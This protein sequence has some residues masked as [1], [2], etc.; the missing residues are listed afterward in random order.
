MRDELLL[1][2]HCISLT[3][4]LSRHR[5]RN[6]ISQKVLRRLVRRKNLSLHLLAED[7]KRSFEGDMENV[8]ALAAEV[9]PSDERN[10]PNRDILGLQKLLF[11]CPNLKSFSLGITGGYGGCVVYRHIYDR[12]DAFQ[13]SGDET[14]PP[15]EELSL[16]GYRLREDEW[17]HWQELLQWS[18]LRSLTLGP[19]WQADFLELAEGYATSLQNLTVEVYTDA[20]ERAVCPQLEEFLESF[21]SLESLTVKGYVVP[22]TPV[23]YHP[24]LKHL[25]L[26][27]FTRGSSEKPRH[28]YSVKKL[29]KLDNIC[30]L[31]ETLELDLNRDGEWVSMIANFHWWKSKAD[32]DAIIARG[33]S[34]NSCDGV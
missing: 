1:R 24:G 4:I 23:S 8:V 22:L 21:S 34:Q 30:P 29:Q 11:G 32:K 25:C 14:F 16:S 19:R 6:R 2:I 27:S 33:I 31:L 9:C 13:F 10:G 26:H 3:G 12:V 18:K 17:E 28:A 7:G 15:L 5:I 20:D